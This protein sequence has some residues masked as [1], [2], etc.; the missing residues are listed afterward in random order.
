MCSFMQVPE[1]CHSFMQTE[2]I[3]NTVCWVLVVVCMGVIFYF[4]SRTAT[5]SSAQS[6]S[7]LNIIYKLFGENGVT[8]FIVRKIAHFLEF[9][10]LCFLFSITFYQQF[11]K[12]KFIL[13]VCCTSLYA[14][15]DEVHQLFVEG[16]ACKFFDWVIDTAGGLFGFLI[17]LIAFM[18]IDKIIKVKRAKKI[19]SKNF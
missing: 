12:V 5:E 2:K 8:T 4:S 3:K 13:P 14:V 9:A 7:I 6:D 15:T 19:D 16:R 11:K 10:G 18:I 17:F 1:G